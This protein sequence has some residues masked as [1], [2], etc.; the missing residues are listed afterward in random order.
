MYHIYI[1]ANWINLKECTQIIYIA[2]SL[3]IYFA[4][5]AMTMTFGPIERIWMLLIC[6]LLFSCKHDQRIRHE[7]NSLQFITRNIYWCQ[8]PSKWVWHFEIMFLGTI[9]PSKATYMAHTQKC[10]HM[11][12]GSIIYF[13]R[14][15]QV[16]SPPGNVVSMLY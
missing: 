16:I 15:D 8:V 2:W 14:F 13:H 4:W 6:I 3:I 12:S 1:T 5:W 10:L 7:S 9:V 11:F